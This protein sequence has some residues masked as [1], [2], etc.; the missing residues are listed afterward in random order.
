MA[1][2]FLIIFFSLETRSA[3][4]GVDKHKIGFANSYE[5]GLNREKVYLQTNR[6]RPYIRQLPDNSLHRRGDRPEFQADLL[7]IRVA[8]RRLRSHPSAA[9][10][11]FLV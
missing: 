5:Q 10:H 7:P 6:K 11:W 1:R 3:H 2:N 9:H 8:V 4:E